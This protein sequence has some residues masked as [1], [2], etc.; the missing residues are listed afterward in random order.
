MGLSEMFMLPCQCLWS[1]LRSH[2]STHSYILQNSYILQEVITVHS[3][4]RAENT[5]HT[6]HW[7]SVNTAFEVRK[8]GN[9][10]GSADGMSSF[11]S[12]VF[13]RL[14]CRWHSDLNVNYFPNNF[15]NYTINYMKYLQ[16]HYPSA[17]YLSSETGIRI[18]CF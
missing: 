3:G 13:H 8:E 18:W 7:E 10:M 6:P 14:L 1:D 15:A 16:H 4:T 2:S 11:G 9:W 17:P 12:P 5:N